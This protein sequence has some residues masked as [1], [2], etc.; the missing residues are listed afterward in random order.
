MGYLSERVVGLM[1]AVTCG[2]GVIVRVQGEP[3]RLFCR[4]SG[5]RGKMLPARCVFERGEKSSLP[6]C[7]EGGVQET[8]SWP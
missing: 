2:R 5:K 3:E 8:V 6:F 1:R 7:P 4:V